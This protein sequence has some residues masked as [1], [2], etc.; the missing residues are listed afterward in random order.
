M[1]LVLI[2]A[3]NL[4]INSCCQESHQT[5]TVISSSENTHLLKSVDSFCQKV[6][7]SANSVCAPPPSRVSVSNVTAELER[8]C[9]G[10]S[11]R[12]THCILL[13]VCFAVTNST[14]KS[15]HVAPSVER[16]NVFFLGFSH[17]C[18]FL[19]SPSYFFS[20]TDL[21]QIFHQASW[22]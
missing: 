1:F 7:H 13:R 18:A 16:G 5:V 14:V 4:K 10:N 21:M 12:D 20:H 11:L 3:I 17:C 22:W 19:F 9:A 6:R 2:A 8:V 15:A